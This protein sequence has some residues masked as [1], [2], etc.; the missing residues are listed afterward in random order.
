MMKEETD[1]IREALGEASMLFMSQDVRGIHMVMPT[2]ELNRIAENL[3]KDLFTA[4]KEELKK[5][6]ENKYAEI[7]NGV[8]DEYIKK[9][10][11]IKLL[12]R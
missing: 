7:R 6:V 8:G 4:Y 2:E 1:K 11:V 9:E 3:A 12:E 10:D 5:E